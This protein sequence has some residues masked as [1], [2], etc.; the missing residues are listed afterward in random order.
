MLMEGRGVVALMYTKQLCWM[1][2][3]S[4]IKKKKA[5]KR[6]RKQQV[7]A[8]E[9]WN[10]RAWLFRDKGTHKIHFSDYIF[11]RLELYVK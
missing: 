1:K 2:I 10:A 3:K 6:T 11:D 9:D 5:Y 8:V 4:I 7:A